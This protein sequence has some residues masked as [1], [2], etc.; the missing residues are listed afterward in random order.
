[1]ILSLSFQTNHL[2][3]NLSTYVFVC[4]APLKVACQEFGLGSAIGINPGVADVG[5][6]W[7]AENKSGWLAAS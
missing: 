7:L 5:H 3:H 4:G 2:H 1:M 6:Y